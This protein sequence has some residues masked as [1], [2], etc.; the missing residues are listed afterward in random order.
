[1]VLSIAIKHLEFY[2][3][4]FNSIN[5]Q[6]FVYTY[7]NGLAVLFLTIQFSINQQS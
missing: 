1:M 4:L 6:S 5:T 2:A 3:N 7:L